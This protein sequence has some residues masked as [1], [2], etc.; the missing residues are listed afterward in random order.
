MTTAASPPVVGVGASAGGVEALI[1]LCEA[2]P[3]DLG[4]VV[5]VVLHIPSSGA[6][7]LASIL[8]RRSDLEVTTARDGDALRPGRVLVAPADHHLLAFGDHVELDRSPLVDG[9]R[10][11]IDALLH[12]IAT[13]ARE[14]GVGV[15]LS[16]SRSDGADGLAAIKAAGGLAFVQDPEEAQ[17]PAMPSAALERTAVD[18]CLTLAALAVRLGQLAD[19]VTPA[20]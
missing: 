11:S 2:L 1:E 19:P 17:F 20:R 12:S 10:P 8:N 16:G 6:S 4:A 13:S 7:V 9:H 18:G 3:A 14:H 5:L 15:V